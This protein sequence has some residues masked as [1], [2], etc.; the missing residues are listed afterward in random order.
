M[1][2]AEPYKKKEKRPG[3]ANAIVLAL[4]LDK[5]TQKRHRVYYEE[6]T[7]YTVRKDGTD[8]DI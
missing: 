7:G 3:I 8:D 1:T 5:E 6:H 4:R 2:E